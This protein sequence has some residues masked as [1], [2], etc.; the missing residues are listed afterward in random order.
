LQ[1][2]KGPLEVLPVV[3]ELVVSEDAEFIVIEEL[4]AYGFLLYM[5]K[6]EE[7]IFSCTSRF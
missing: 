7:G 5:K 4:G 2:S 1:A 3:A 6:Q